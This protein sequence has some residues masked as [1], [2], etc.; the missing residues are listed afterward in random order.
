MISLTGFT[1]VPQDPISDTPLSET[2]AIVESCAKIQWSAEQL[3]DPNWFSPRLTQLHDPMLM[4]GMEKAVKRLEFALQTN[5]RIRIITD[6]D[7]DGTTSSLILQATLR[8]LRPDVA[9]DYHIPG[10][11]DEGYGFSTLAAQ[12]A[13]DDQI[14][15]IITADIGIRDQA[16][17]NVAQE[18]NVDVL[19]C[20][21]HLPPGSDIPTGAFVLCPPQKDC[22]YPN[23]HLA[24]C[25]V[26][27][28]L[29]QAMLQKNPRFEL[30][31]KSMLKL[32]AIGT[33]SDM[34]PLT[35]AENRAIVSL[36][37]IELNE[38]RHGAGLEA[39]LSAC[40]AT[41]G[42]IDEGT[43]GYQI[44]PRI[45]AAGR[46]ADAKIIVEMLNCRKPQQ[47]KQLAKKVDDMNREGDIDQGSLGDVG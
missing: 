26:T 21:H 19:I 35:T 38:A 24:A 22:E 4:L 10:R 7:V 5:Q 18:N 16:A 39:L 31:F 41:R 33:V 47:A 30:I 27:L 42:Q 13:V 44:G 29:A 9:L 32:A 3:N 34:V 25:G 43:I 6:Y 17:V 23:P 11:F 40:K 20:D 14:D 1:W 8:I 2:K 45:N 15:L 46:M 12:R 28:K 36:G 37:L